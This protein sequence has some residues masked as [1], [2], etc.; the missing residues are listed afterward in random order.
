MAC[1]TNVV[2]RLKWVRS[3]RLSAIASDNMSSLRVQSSYLVIGRYRKNIDV[4]TVPA[5]KIRLIY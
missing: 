4:I 2:L 1:F 5:N 3:G